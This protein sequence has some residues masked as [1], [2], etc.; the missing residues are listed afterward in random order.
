MFTNVTRMNHDSIRLHLCKRILAALLLLAIVLA[1]GCSKSVKITAGQE[2]AG[3]PTKPADI[4]FLPL[5]S[6]GTGHYQV[7]GKLFARHKGG[8]F[9]G[10]GADDLKGTI[11]SGAAKL[12][13]DVVIG[14]KSGRQSDSEM[15][16]G[17]SG[18]GSGIAARRIN[19]SSK[20]P[21]RQDFV[22]ALCGDRSLSF[23]NWKASQVENFKVEKAKPAVKGNYATVSDP[24]IDTSYEAFHK[25]SS[26]MEKSWKYMLTA[27][28][29]QLEKHG[30]YAVLTPASEINI[31]AD[32]IG[33]FGA[34]QFEQLFG[35][36]ASY[37]NHIDL[38]GVTG[39]NAAFVAGASARVKA[40]L[41]SADDDKVVW[42][43][44]ADESISNI[45]VLIGSG[46]IGG[47]AASLLESGDSRQQRAV[48]KAMS[49]LYDN[50]APINEK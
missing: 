3:S 50:L 1:A 34:D 19:G 35:P 47:V 8:M 49:K 16:S 25:D 15:K 32:S 20:I 40:M 44:S 13:A 37:V 11:G 10:K 39:Y 14:F 2:E 48:C 22:A 9:M 46:L 38:T 23:E 5:D 45:G 28:E 41:Y 43:N 33:T 24:V 6:L 29:F 12:G 30:Y 18:W 42:T 31:G 26:K 36:Y 7:V 4:A 17:N 21:V 27:A